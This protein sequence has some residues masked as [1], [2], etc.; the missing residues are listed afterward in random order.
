M[1]ELIEIIKKNTGLSIRFVT[2]EYN[3]KYLLPNTIRIES[4]DD[5]TISEI[6][7]SIH[8]NKYEYLEMLQDCYIYT[9]EK[10]LEKYKKLK[11]I[12]K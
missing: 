7:E 12:Q 6:E 1:K 8:I 4:V 9:E 3:T 11:N 5:L 2:A 10:F